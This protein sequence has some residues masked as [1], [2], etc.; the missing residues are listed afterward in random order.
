MSEI[1][2]GLNPEQIKAVTTVHGPV[3]VLAG[4]GSGKTRVLTRRIAHLIDEAGVAPWHILGRHLHQQ[5]RGRDARARRGDLRREVRPAAPRAS[6][7]AW[8]G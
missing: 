6:P 5:G 7:R 3:L 8:A 1:L 2:A 4:P